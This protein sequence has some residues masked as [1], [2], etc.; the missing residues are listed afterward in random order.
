MDQSEPRDRGQAIPCRKASSGP[1]WPQASAATGDR[2]SGP[3]VRY[4]AARRRPAGQQVE[5]VERDEQRG[6]AHLAVRKRWLEE[7]ASRRLWRPE[8]ETG[9]YCPNC[10]EREFRKPAPPNSTQVT[11]CIECARPW[12]V[13]TEHW[14]VYLTDDDPP[15]AVSYCPACAAEEFG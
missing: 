10:V 9:V 5:V 15:E 6:R 14:R 7:V 12:E 13:P 1:P 4:Q 11:E 2:F 8:R 3:Q